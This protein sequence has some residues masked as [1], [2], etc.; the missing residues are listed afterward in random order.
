ME[1]NILNAAADEAGGAGEKERLRK[2]AGGLGWRYAI[3]AI[4]VIGI[5]I[6]VSGV[7]SAVAPQWVEANVSLFQFL[8]IILSVDIIGFPLIFILSKKIPAV[9]LESHNLGFGKLVVCVLMGAGICGVG[10]IIGNI[11]HF[12]LTLPFGV[13]LDDVNQLGNM[14]LYSDAPIRILTV[15][16]LAPIFEELIFRKLLVD[17]MINHGE[18]AAILMSGLMF[19]LFHGNFSQFFYATGLGLF[20][21]FIYIKTGK[22]WYTIL[23]HMIVNLSSSVVTVYLS[24]AYLQA[25]QTAGEDMTGMTQEGMLSM[26]V[27]LGWMGILLVCCIAGVILLIVNRKKFSLNANAAGMSKKEAAGSALSSKGMLLYYIPCIILFLMAYGTPIIN[28]FV[29]K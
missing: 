24:Q 13:S 7:L 5:Q 8:L 17:R 29:N 15:G 27:Y 19:G 28:L 21:A 10:G 1:T 12:A 25:L 20:W 4:A 26:L 22:I 2:T 16:I 14:M 18:F 6:L 9:R 23:F 3:F 11:F